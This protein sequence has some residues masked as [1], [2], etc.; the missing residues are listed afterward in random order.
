MKGTGRNAHG[1][2]ERVGGVPCA[3][4]L[5][6]QFDMVFGVFVFSFFLEGLKG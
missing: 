5:L 1:S 2:S 3:Y 6:S 4:I